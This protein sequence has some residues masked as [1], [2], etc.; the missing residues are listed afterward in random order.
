MQGLAKGLGITGR[1]LSPTFIIVRRYDVPDTLL[2]LYHMDAYRMKSESDVEGVGFTEMLAHPQALVIVEWPE[3][4][5]R[6]LPK[7]RLDIHFETLAD[8][9]HHIDIQNI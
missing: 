6:L 1:L 3:R 9:D 4:L 7:H 5:G 2:Y 8:D